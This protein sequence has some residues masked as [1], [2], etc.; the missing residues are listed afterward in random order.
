MTPGMS[1]DDFMYAMPE[2]LVEEIMTEYSDRTTGHVNRRFGNFRDSWRLFSL[3]K[4]SNGEETH[5]A[6]SD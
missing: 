6:Y 5:I 4:Y 3:L 1:L 2:P